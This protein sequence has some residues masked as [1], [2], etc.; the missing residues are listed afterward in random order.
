MDVNTI[1]DEQVP[2]KQAN[3]AKYMSVIWDIGSQKKQK[4]LHVAYKPQT[5][6]LKRMN[7]FIET[8]VQNFT[9]PL[10]FKVKPRTL[11]LNKE[12]YDLGMVT[13]TKVKL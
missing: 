3:E 7:L 1:I 13:N 4:F 6:G 2:E 9:V 11:I 10:N 5:L 8:G 12:L